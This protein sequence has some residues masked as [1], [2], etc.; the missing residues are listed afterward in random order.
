MKTGADFDRHQQEASEI[1][2]R[3]VAETIDAVK[4]S[5]FAT[6]AYQRLSRVKQHLAAAQKDAQEAEYAVNRAQ[7][8][9]AGAVISGTDTEAPDA[10][11]TQALSD[12]NRAKQVIEILSKELPATREA[13]AR[14][15]KAAAAEA[16]EDLDASF[17]DAHAALTEKLCSLWQQHATQ[18]AV[19]QV[20]RDALATHPRSGIIEDAIKEAIG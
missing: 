11:L 4:K 19:S 6:P 13:A 3:R 8:K 10:L 15:L 1:V 20:A 5:F 18:I 2:K 7:R 9:F 16:L 17:G 12:Q 14:E